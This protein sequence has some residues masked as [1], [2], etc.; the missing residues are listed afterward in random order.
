MQPLDITHGTTFKNIEDIILNEKQQTDKK[1]YLTL[2]E[3]L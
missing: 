3:A 2:Y 1:Y